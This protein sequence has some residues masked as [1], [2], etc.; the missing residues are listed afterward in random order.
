[1]DTTTRKSDAGMLDYNAGGQYHD[2]AGTPR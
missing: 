2:R 1:M